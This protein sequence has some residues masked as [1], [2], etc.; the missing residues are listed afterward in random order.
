MMAFFLLM[1]LINTTSPQHHG[2]HEVGVGDLPRAA[3]VARFAALLD[4]LDDDRA[5]AGG[6]HWLIPNEAVRSN[7]VRSGR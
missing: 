4:L 3:V 5:F 2:G 6:G 7:R 1:W